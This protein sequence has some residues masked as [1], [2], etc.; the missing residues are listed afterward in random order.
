MMGGGRKLYTY[1]RVGG[2]GK[3]CS[4]AEGGWGTQQ[5]VAMLKGGGGAQKV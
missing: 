3:S 5:V 1:I 2:G 4:H